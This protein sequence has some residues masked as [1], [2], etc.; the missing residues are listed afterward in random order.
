MIGDAEFYSEDV[1]QARRCE[2]A[3]RT[4]REVT[5]TYDTPTGEKSV[6]GTVTSVCSEVS[7]DQ[8][9]RWRISIKPRSTLAS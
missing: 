8:G 7:S 5:E 1:E 6:T 4:K 3:Q 2:E 9:A